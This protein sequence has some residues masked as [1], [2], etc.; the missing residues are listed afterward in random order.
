MKIPRLL[1][2]ARSSI[3]MDRS[4]VQSPAFPFGTM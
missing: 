1:L 4:W 2:L 3:Y